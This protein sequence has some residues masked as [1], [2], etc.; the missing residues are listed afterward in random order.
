[1]ERVI[2]RDGHT[3]ADAILEQL[4]RIAN[5]LEDITKTWKYLMRLKGYN[6]EEEAD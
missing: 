1:M 6:L 4:E 2:D 3:V 5:S